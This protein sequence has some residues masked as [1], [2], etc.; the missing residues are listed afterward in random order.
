MTRA[1]S[2]PARSAVPALDVG[3]ADRADRE[4]ATGARWEPR[5]RIHGRASH[6]IRPPVPAAIA[7]AR[8]LQNAAELPI[9]PRWWEADPLSA[10]QAPTRDPSAGTLPRLPFDR[11]HRST[12][13]IRPC[14]RVTP[15]ALTKRRAGSLTTGLTRGVHAPGLPRQQRIPHPEVPVVARS[16]RLPRPRLRCPTCGGAPRL[17]ADLRQSLRCQC[18][19]LLRIALVEARPVT[20]TPDFDDD[21]LPA[22]RRWWDK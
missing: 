21:P 19:A 2:H 3:R 4:T 18:G 12:G 20:L 1:V 6:P 22:A 17:P 9:A 8:L 16:N 5:P 11:S 13:E 10:G 7:P 15:S 14:V